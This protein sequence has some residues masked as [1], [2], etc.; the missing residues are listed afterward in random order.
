MADEVTKRLER[1]LKKCEKPKSKWDNVVNKHQRTHHGNT[2]NYY[3]ILN[4][5]CS[6]L[7]IA[8]GRTHLCTL[9]TKG[10]YTL[11]SRHLSSC[12]IT[13]AVGM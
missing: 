6:Y 3:A 4:D 9:A 2:F 1:K 11:S 13:C 5:V 7:E 10:G 12:D 8:R